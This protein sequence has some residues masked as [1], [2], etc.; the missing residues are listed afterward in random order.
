MLSSLFSKQKLWLLRQ[1]KRR[2]VTTDSVKTK[3]EKIKSQLV[4]LF[5]SEIDQQELNLLDGVLNVDS[6]FTLQVNRVL[7][8][9]AQA[10]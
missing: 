3:K 10:D 2:I 9:I 7:D 1:Q 5:E 8:P 4:R 6:P